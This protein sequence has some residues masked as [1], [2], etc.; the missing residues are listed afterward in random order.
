MQKQTQ[1]QPKKPTPISTAKVGVAFRLS[2]SVVNVLDKQA[3][4]HNL[5]RSDMVRHALYRDLKATYGVTVRGDEVV[6]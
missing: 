4:K 2:K 1:K 3:A 6:D 5:D